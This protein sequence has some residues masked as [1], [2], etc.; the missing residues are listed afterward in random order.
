[1]AQNFPGSNNIN[2]LLP[3]GNFGHRKQLG[4]DAASPRYIFTNTNRIAFKIFR[5]EDMPLLNY[6]VEEGKEVEPEVY[7]P[8]LPMILIN[9]TSGIGSGFATDIFPYNP[10]EVVKV[11]KTFINN[12][13][14]F[15]I[16]PWFRGFTGD[17]VKIDNYKYQMKGKYEIIDDDTVLITEIP[18]TTSLE[19][20][21]EFLTTV[22]ILDKKENDPKK[23]IIDFEMKPYVNKVEIKVVFKPTELQKLL[24]NDSLETYLKLNTTLSL[25]NMHLYNPQNKLLKYDTIYEIF[26]E[27]YIYRLDLYEKRKAYH[28]K[29][30]ENEVDLIKYKVK[31]IES[32]FSKEIII[33]KQKKDTVIA[34]LEQ[35]KFPKLAKNI[36]NPDR[37]YSYL[38]ELP[39]WCL[40]LEKIEE[41]KKE[42]K[43]IQKVLQDYMSK[44][45]Q[46][47]W[48]EELDEFVDTYNKW[49]DELN[50]HQAKEDELTVKK[51]KAKVSKKKV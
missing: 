47:I 43:D 35:L 38:T 42:L 48:N 29:V 28:I 6:I 36:K 49:V 10:L 24:K 31:F 2:L 40:T 41:L 22:E 45:V 27:F 9:G 13:D 44:T 3:N 18:I 32:I 25:T 39:L 12:K 21:K 46:D 15:E 16:A 20:Y 51:P 34:R 7:T 33:E 19:S 37:S 14:Y 23:K 30:L 4:K 1:M 11:L 5:D 50:E 17:I 26:E 8:I